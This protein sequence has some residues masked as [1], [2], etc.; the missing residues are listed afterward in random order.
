VTKF[1]R[2]YRTIVD[3]AEASIAPYEPPPII[4]NAP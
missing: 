4:V 1:Y 3:V 2:R